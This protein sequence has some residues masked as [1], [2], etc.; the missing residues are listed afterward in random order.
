L[1]SVDDAVD[2]AFLPDTS[3]DVSFGI[4]VPVVVTCFN[5]C[6]ATTFDAELFNL[7]ASS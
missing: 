6:T 2:A 5:V 3:F 4:I 7:I 1:R